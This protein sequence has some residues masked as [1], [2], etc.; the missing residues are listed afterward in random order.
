MS[1]SMSYS[2]T[3]IRELEFPAD[4]C[5]A[6]WGERCRGVQGLG[7][8]AKAPRHTD[9][10]LNSTSNASSSGALPRYYAVFIA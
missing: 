8:P 7:K 9:A 6:Q 4:S 5:P 10:S 2:N 1:Q 3:M